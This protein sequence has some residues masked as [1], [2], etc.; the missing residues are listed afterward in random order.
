MSD[1]LKEA[2]IKIKRAHITLMRHEETRMFA[3][4][5]ADGNT[6]VT[7]NE[8]DCPTAY[9]DGR[10]CVY[11]AKFVAPLTDAQAR[12]LVMHE[13]GHKFLM[14]L[15]RMTPEMKEDPRTANQAMDYAINGIIMA[16]KDTT[17]FEPIPK[18]LHDTKYAGWSFVRIFKDLK[19]KRQQQQQASGQ[20]QGQGQQSDGGHDGFDVHDIDKA[21]A[22]DAEVLQEQAKQIVETLRQGALM[23]G[24]GSSGVAQA[25]ENALAPPVNWQKELAEFV[26]ETTS[27][28]DELTWRRYDRRAMADDRYMPTYES[29][30]VTELLI[31]VDT[32]GSTTGRVLSEFMATMQ[33]ICETAKPQ[34]VRVLFWDAKVCGEQ[35]LTDQYDNLT[36]ILKPLGGGGTRVGCVSDYINANGYHPTAVIVLTDGYVESEVQ[37]AV[38]APTLWMSTQNREFIPPTGRLVHIEG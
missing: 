17:L 4:F 32:S 37:W 35:L 3:P 19:Q 13:Q 21:Q 5:F 33:E 20:G 10:S 23:A 9:T 18:M 8:A 2:T 38:S 28:K 1:L 36:K 34:A 30:T 15:I 6:E 31:A 16:F 26:N 7:D 29:E 24:T 22:A 14:H 11:G 27:G 12:L 25:I